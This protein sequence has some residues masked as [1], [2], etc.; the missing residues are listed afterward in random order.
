M[1]ACLDLHVKGNGGVF[2]KDA[3]K[4]NPFYLMIN[5]KKLCMP[6][7]RSYIHQLLWNIAAT[8]VSS[9]EGRKIWLWREQLTCE[10]FV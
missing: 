4:S 2:T 3:L 5:S 10:F 1:R 7:I 8:A 9:P 6:F